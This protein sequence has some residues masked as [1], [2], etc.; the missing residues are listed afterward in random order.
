[1]LVGVLNPDDRDPLLAR[2]LNE[3]ADVRHHRLPL[4]GRGDGA[5]LHVDDE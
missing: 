2:L 4:V 3:P 1:M 5:V